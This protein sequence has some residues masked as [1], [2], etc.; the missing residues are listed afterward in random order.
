MEEKILNKGDMEQMRL[1]GFPP[2]TQESKKME[3]VTVAMQKK[4]QS[5][6]IKPTGVN[7]GGGV[8]KDG[9]T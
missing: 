1:P 9:R 3:H 6:M 2:V 5:N 4:V 8:I 7:M